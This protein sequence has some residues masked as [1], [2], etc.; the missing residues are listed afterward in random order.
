MQQFF[1]GAWGIFK[2]RKTEYFSNQLIDNVNDVQ[3]TA[4]F[5]KT[6]ASNMLVSPSILADLRAL[7]VAF[8][9][10]SN[11]SYSSCKSLI[12]AHFSFLKTKQFTF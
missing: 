4:S 9:R 10:K 2:Q 8:R 6:Q 5:E 12:T 11:G 1:E 7:S 3:K